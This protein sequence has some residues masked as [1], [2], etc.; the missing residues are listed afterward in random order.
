MHYRAP[1]TIRTNTAFVLVLTVVALVL[2][3][4][5]EVAA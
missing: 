5:A 2:V 3:G 1:G 4:I